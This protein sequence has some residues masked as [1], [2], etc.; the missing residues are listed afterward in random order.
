MVCYFLAASR[1]PCL[2]FY[3]NVV[4]PEAQNVKRHGAKNEKTQAQRKVVSNTRNLEETAMPKNIKAWAH[5]DTKHQGFESF[6]RPLILPHFLEK[7]K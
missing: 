5:A 6:A 2:W 3:D 1:N 4:F 7:N